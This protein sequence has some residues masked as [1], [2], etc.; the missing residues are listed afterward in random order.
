M[1]NNASRYPTPR[2]DADNRPMVEGWQ[3]GRLVLPKCRAC[4]RVFFYPRPLCPHCWSDELEWHSASGRGKV[5][6][7]SLVRRPNHPAFD[8]LPIVLAE[9]VLDEGPS[10]LARIVQVAPESVSIGMQVDLVPLPL[11]RR[12]PL[13]TF[14]PES[15]SNHR[16]SAQ[17][18]GPN[19]VSDGLT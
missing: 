14:R 7:F 4:G 18:T 1:T 9:L 19:G 12:F 17:A 5:V 13:P 11:A 15:R 16:K 6:A 10:I 3:E 2:C 8:E